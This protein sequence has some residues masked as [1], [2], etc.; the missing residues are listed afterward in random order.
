MNALYLKAEGNTV[1]DEKNLIIAGV[2]GST[3]VIDRHGESINPMGWKLENFM[4]EPVILYG[5]DYSSFPVGKALKVYIEDNKLKFNIQFAP[6]EEGKK[7]FQLIQG[8]FLN[9][10]SAGL[11][12]LKWGVSGQDP[13]SI[14]EQELL[15]LSIVP[16][17][18]NPEAL[19]QNALDPLTVAFKELEKMLKVAEEKALKEKEEK[20]KAE[21][22]LKEKIEELEKMGYKVI[23]EKLYKEIEEV[24]K[25]NET[26]TNELEEIKSGRVLSEKNRT[27]IKN[28]IDQMKAAVDDLQKLLSATE[29]EKDAD[30]NKEQ[31]SVLQ[32]IRDTMRNSDKK[33]GLALK[34]LNE[35]VAK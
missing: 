20:E 7:T 15:E 14:M 8:G 25:L 26:L 3:G 9:T 34:K 29:P 30:P 13:Y 27:L 2:I 12:P 32:S 10:T 31:S 11:I 16:V 17:P 5:H 19:I 28:T 24:K 22:E 4:K 1:I 35:V 33:I 23:E 21:K 18:A 6:T